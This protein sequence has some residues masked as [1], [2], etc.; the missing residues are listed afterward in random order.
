M[1]EEFYKKVEFLCKKISNV[2]WSGILLYTYEG[3]IAR[4]ESFIITLKDIILMDK[5][6]SGAT[7][8]EFNGGEDDFH[9]DYMEKYPD[10]RSWKIGHIHSHNTMGVFFSATDTGELKDNASAHNIYVSLIVNND[11]KTCCR[12]CY[13]EEPLINNISFQWQARN[14]KGETYI[15]RST[16]NVV[17]DKCLVTHEAEVEISFPPENVFNDFFLENIQKVLEKEEEKRKTIY[18]H[19]YPKHDVGFY[20]S[21]SRKE[22]DVTVS[23]SLITTYD[24]IKKLFL[25]AKICMTDYPTAGDYINFIKL[26][27]RVSF[28]HNVIEG[29][30]LT[31]F[32]RNFSS[33]RY[34][35]GYI[36]KK[37]KETLNPVLEEFFPTAE[38]Y[39]Q[40]QARVNTAI[41][42]LEG[43]AKLFKS[44]KSV[45]NAL[46]KYGR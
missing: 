42:H 21:S 5:G 2:E 10:R 44:A 40:K 36:E 22:V 34:G 25:A 38:N 35:A 29:E 28:P 16:E 24:P 6:S 41:K 39:W 7:E 26:L 31:E 12:I 43:F 46:E 13:I 19:P 27:V 33:L 17:V 14:E 32:F 1:P 9:I 45:I 11:M 18:G 15:S 8:Y 30:E 3:T 23:K 4:P 20:E 37:I